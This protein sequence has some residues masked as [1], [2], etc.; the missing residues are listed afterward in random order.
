MS[1]SFWLVAQNNSAANFR[2][3][4][5]TNLTNLLEYSSLFVVNRATWP[6][7][8]AE[9]CKTFIRRFESGRRLSIKLAPIDGSPA[10][11]LPFRTHSS[12]IN[13]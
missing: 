13:L 12:I 9:V 1:P 5:L 8:K 7:G 10:I 4:A 6:S 11:F 3:N 2:A